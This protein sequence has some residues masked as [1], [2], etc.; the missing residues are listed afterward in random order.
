MT[1]NRRDFLKLA[2]LGAGAPA[3]V[4]LAR[5]TADRK[6]FKQAPSAMPNII[7]ILADDIGYGDLS[8]YGATRVRTP[9][10][11]RLAKE[12]VRFTDAHASCSVCSPTRYSLLTGQYAFRNPAGDHILS[13]EE[14]L[15]IDRASITVP[16]LLKR[17]GYISAV[18]GKWHIG[19]GKGRGDVNRNKEIAPGPLEVGFDYA[20]YY[21]WVTKRTF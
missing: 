12:G 16:S 1:T 3:L 8:C 20:F 9:N 18:V 15:A 5:A 10:S 21:Y 13:G 14:P 2:G 4:A 6:A 7:V 17:A 11:D 19:V